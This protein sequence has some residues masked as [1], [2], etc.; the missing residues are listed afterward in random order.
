ML[1]GFTKC[2]PVELAY[3]ERPALFPEFDRDGPA[4]CCVRFIRM[5]LG[6]RASSSSNPCASFA[7]SSRSKIA[8]TK[9]KT[10]N[11]IAWG[12]HSDAGIAIFDLEIGALCNAK[13]LC[14]H[15]T[16]QAALAAR[17]RNVPTK[18]GKVSYHLDGQYVFDD[19]SHHLTSHIEVHK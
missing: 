3:T 18:L 15:R 7:G 8:P 5:H 6:S 16:G 12:C 2:L 19:G 10:K 4:Y 17:N 1:N 13:P 11:A 9:P 14:H